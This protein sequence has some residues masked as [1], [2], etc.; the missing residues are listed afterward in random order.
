MNAGS[1]AESQTT[2]YLHSRYAESLSEFGAPRHLPGSGAW[3][4]ERPIPGTGLRDAMSCYPLFAC[5]NWSELRQDLQELGEG[6]VSFAAVLT[7]FGDYTEESLHEWFSDVCIPFKQ[8]YVAD[9]NLSPGSFVHPHHLRNAHK[10]MAAVQVEHCGTPSDWLQDWVMLYNTLI[11]RHTITGISRFSPAS[12]AKQFSVPGLTVFRAAMEN[13][14]VGMLLWFTDG[15]VG[16]YHLGAYSELGYKVR[17]SFALFA[18]AFEFFA[19]Q[20]VRWLN[21]GGGAGGVGPASSGLARFK[22][23]WS[24]GFRTTYFCGRIFDRKKYE[25]LTKAKGTVG[26]KYFPAYRQGEFR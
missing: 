13:Q 22:Q 18:F 25:E 23:G 17:A 7:P 6:L 16:Y 20:G 10:A 1:T 3:I 21:L 2:G 8:H 5:Q 4:L 9:L 11:E 26:A 14:T 24:S 15:E 12:F 19:R